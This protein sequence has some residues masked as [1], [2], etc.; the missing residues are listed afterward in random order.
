[1]KVLGIDQATTTG[2]AIVSDG[3][4]EFY[5]KKTFDGEWED[6][7]SKIKS[8]MDKIIQYY[9]P[10]IIAIENI[11]YQA[12]QDVYRKLAELKGVLENYLFDNNLDYRIVSPSTWK[13]ICE[14][15]KQGRLSE[16]K[17]SQEFVKKMFNVSVTQDEADAINI[18]YTV[19][20]KN[21]E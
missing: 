11:Q 10:D 2:V 16:K 8:Y 19:W 13:S 14:I 4:L 18:A 12:N 15:K 7:V 3:N 20:L 5:D 6:K 9:S 17:Q 21:K 1:M